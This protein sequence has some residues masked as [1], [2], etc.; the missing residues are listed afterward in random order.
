MGKL[1]VIIRDLVIY[2]AN[3]GFFM[4]KSYVYNGALAALLI[5]IAGTPL[6]TLKIRMYENNHGN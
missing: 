4:Y 1:Q 3:E 5:Y 2:V 6:L